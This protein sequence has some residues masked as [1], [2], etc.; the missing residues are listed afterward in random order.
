MLNH[1]NKHIGSTFSYHELMRTEAKEHGRNMS[2]AELLKVEQKEHRLKK[3]P[4]L[5]QAMMAE[6]AEHHA[7]GRA[8]ATQIYKGQK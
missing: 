4:T 3:T 1:L 2:K 6:Y 7:P 8:K 5:R